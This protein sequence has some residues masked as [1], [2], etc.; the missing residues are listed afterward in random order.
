MER[1]PRT[2]IR[3]LVKQALIN[4][5][6][7]IIE[8]RIFTSRARALNEKELPAIMVFFMGEQNKGEDTFPPVYN[9]TL[10]LVIE[11]LVRVEDRDSEAGE[12]TSDEIARQVE[13]ALLT[14]N[15]IDD[16]APGN[17]ISKVFLEETAFDL[18]KAEFLTLSQKLRFTIRYN[19]EIFNNEAPNPFNSF[20]ADIKGPEGLAD[21]NYLIQIEEDLAQ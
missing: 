1:H 9:R 4:Q 8:G 5:N 15:Y 12:V 3:E 19:E 6:I 14:Q 16:S 2:A 10:H 18:D 7:T 13:R 21:K 17:P 20:T 11:I